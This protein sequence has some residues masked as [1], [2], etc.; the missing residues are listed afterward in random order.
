[1]RRHFGIAGD[2]LDVLL[3][4]AELIGHDLADDRLGAL[5]LLGDRDQAAHVAGRRE[6]RIAPSCEE[7]RAPPTP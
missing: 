7:M 5:P 1:M 2:D 4:D 6:L 3:R